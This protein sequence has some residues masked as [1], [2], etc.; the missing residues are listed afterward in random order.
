MAKFDIITAA[1]NAYK[2]T[3]ASRQYLLRLAA[4]P[5]ALKLIFF[6][7]ASIYAGGNDTEDSNYILFMLILV[8]ALIAEGWMLAHWIRFLVLGQTWPFQPTGDVEADKKMLSTRARG[9][10]SGM[11][12]FVLINMAIGFLNDIV[13]R[14]M[15]PYMSLNPET[16]MDKVP[17]I[18]PV[19]SVFFLAFMFWGFRLLWLHVPFALNMP[20]R[21]YIL[22]LKGATSSIYMIGVWILC[23]APFILLLKFV[24]P[25]LLAALPGQAGVSAVTVISILFDTLKSIIATAGITFGLK[26]IFSAKIDRRV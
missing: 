16:E 24:G 10:L 21:D 23:F 15:T 3:W 17:A 5:V 14:A 12:V 25:I 1:A 9:I 26:E 4:V 19:F 22:R 2:T 6:T 7:I 20:M 18:I 13:A 11:I 8:P